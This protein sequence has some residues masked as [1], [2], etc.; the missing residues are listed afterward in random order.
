LT[1]G[2]LLVSDRRSPAIFATK[3]HAF[4][5][6]VVG[7]LEVVFFRATNEGSFRDLLA[8]L[9]RKVVCESRL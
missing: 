7:R 2:W 6:M 3:G 1:G 9:T 8:T 5:T 4:P